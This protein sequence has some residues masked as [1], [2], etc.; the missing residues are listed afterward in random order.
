MIGKRI[1]NSDYTNYL[2]TQKKKVGAEK[3]KKKKGILEMD[4]TG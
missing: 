1:S 4:E 3:K 2:A